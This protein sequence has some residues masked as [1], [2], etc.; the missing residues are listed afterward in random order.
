MKKAKLKIVILSGILLI[1]LFLTA[2]GKQKQ[3]L[4]FGKEVFFGIKTT[5]KMIFSKTEERPVQAAAGNSCVWVLTMNQGGIYEQAI[6]AKTVQ[7]LKWQQEEQE[8]ITGISAVE[9]CLYAAVACGETVQVRKFPRGHQWETLLSIPTEE[10][11]RQVQPTVFFVDRSENAYFA[12]EDEILK[13]SPGSKERT[14]YHLKGETAFLQEKKPGIVEA[15]VKSGSNI[16]LYS[17]PEDRK[18]EERWTLPL[19]TTHLETIRTEDTGTLVLAADNKIL[20]INN[21]TGEI[22][23]HFNSMEAGVSTGL[24]GG[25]WLPEEGALYL[26]EQGG[27]TE[28][29]WEKLAAQNGPEGDRAVLVYGTVSLSEAMR[30]RITSFNKSNPDY[31]ITVKEYTGETIS[32]QRLQM[33]TAVTSGKGPDI[34]DLSSYCVDNYTAYAEK[35]YLEDLGPWLLTED[36]CDDLLQTIHELYRIDGRLC[37]AVPHFTLWGFA[38]NPEYVSETEGWNYQTFTEAAAQAAQSLPANR[39]GSAGS[40]LAPLL[41]GRQNE[42]IRYDEKKAYFDTPEFISLLEF[43]MEYRKKNLLK[44]NAADAAEALM[45]QLSVNDSV[46]YLNT[47]IC[48]GE[49]AALYGYPTAEGQ[50]LLINNTVDAC[51]IYALSEN[52]EGAWEFI[53]TLYTEDYQRKMTGFKSAWA[54]RASCWYAQWNQSDAYINGT[55]AAPATEDEIGQLAD[56]LLSGKVTADLLQNTIID[57]ALEE[58]D[59]YFAGDYTAEEAARNIQSRVQLMLNE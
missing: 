52:K 57:L 56:M 19:P 22:A 21:D 1:T 26:V 34:L 38:L 30:E 55:Y 51:G 12:D 54:V 41:R 53:R 9:D 10:A 4:S 29:I 39:N 7:S 43:C 16:T 23:S 50:L 47:H 18:A 45:V 36:F 3:E 35:G 14:V 48:Y 13:Y 58:A 40:L 42:F 11:P 46:S 37:M 44:Y 24:L 27:D 33:Q 15:L 31:Y 59:A 28:G 8:M 6:A 25:L 20:F 5:D 32:D 17:L 2:C 49:T